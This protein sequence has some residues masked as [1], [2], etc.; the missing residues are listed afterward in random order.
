M[1][2]I[3]PDRLFWF[4]AAAALVSV[5][6][7]AEPLARRLG[8]ERDPLRLP[9]AAAPATAEPPLS[10]DPI[11][12]LAPFGRVEQAGAPAP[13]AEETALDLTLH[14]VVIAASPEN[15]RAI[16]SSGAEPPQAY[17]PDD[18]IADVATLV[19]VEHDVVVLEVDGRREALLFSVP[20]AQAAED[21]PA[22]S[23]SVLPQ[24]AEPAPTD[25]ALAISE[26]REGFRDNPYRVLDEL[27]IEA[28]EAG[29]RVGASPAEAVRRAGLRPGDIVDLVNGHR[30]GNVELDRRF[31]DSVAATG[32]ARV[33][34]VRGGDRLVL[35]FPL[36]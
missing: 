17:A 21:A 2:A 9:A 4:A 14:G 23:L 34:V 15:S 5:G 20:A 13:E 19:A 31:Y 6:I 25:T 7:A 24:I 18:R 29:Y 32:Q 16:V 11:H 36:Q 3:T 28:T 12:D 22:R 30:V 8:G 10:L 33:E 27:G 1:K 26:M 35:S